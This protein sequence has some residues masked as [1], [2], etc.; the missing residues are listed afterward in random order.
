MRTKKL[1]PVIKSFISSDEKL[2]TILRAPSITRGPVIE[3]LVLL[4][5]FVNDSQTANGALLAAR[6]ASLQGID[7]NLR[8]LFLT[9]WTKALFIQSSVM[10]KRLPEAWTL[11]RQAENLITPASPPEIV[12]HFKLA[13]SYLVGSEGNIVR[14]EETIKDALSRIKPASHRYKSILVHFASFLAQLGRMNEITNDLTTLVNSTSDADRSCFSAL[15]FIDSVETGRLD[16]ARLFQKKASTL[17]AGSVV[18]PIFD[19]TM[20]LFPLMDPPHLTQTVSENSK[21]KPGNP[22]WALTLQCLSNGQIHQALRWA[23]LWERTHGK[24]IA[25]KGLISFNLIRAELAEGNA[26]AARRL[27][28][29]RRECGNLHYLDEFFLARAELLDGHTKEATAMFKSAMNAVDAHNADGRLDFELRL[30]VE[31]RRDMLMR[32]VRNSYD[33]PTEK[34]NKTISIPERR[35]ELQPTGLQ[36]ITGTSKSLDDVRKMI[37]QFTDLD[38]PVLITG[39]T[40]TGKE[41][42]ARA[43]HESGSRALEPFLAINC[44]AISESLLESELFG[45]EKGAFSGAATSHRGLFEEA[46]KGT[47]LLDEI[48]EISPRLQVALLRVLD[49]MEVRSVGSSRSR[50]IECRI[51]ASTNADL[52]KMVQNNTFRKDILFRL[53]R[54]E[55]NLTPL[56]ERTADILPLAVHFLDINR[57]EGVHA[58]MSASLQKTIMN[59]K[60]PGNVRELRNIIEKMRL[61]HSDK[62]YYDK[63]DLDIRMKPEGDLQTNDL[64]DAEPNIE[65]KTE[66]AMVV[67]IG[68]SRA[69]RLALLRHLFS[70]HDILTRSEIVQTFKISPNTATADLKQLCNEEF[71]LRIKPSKS[72][73][74]VYFKVKKKEENM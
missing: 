34:E 11:L 56:R 73:R 52:N 16:D 19:A 35:E 1:H 68:R 15:Q 62:L 37:L 47:I 38:V 65:E 53:Q 40:G 31:I 46:G 23:R 21:A 43:L 18:A 61:L 55:I 27:L 39:E 69:R 36:R 74:S 71:I 64:P 20:I 41:V 26:S 22:D 30:A 10:K 2:A 59:Y 4:C 45:H 48:G 72:P 17:D 12:S 8:I 60:W 14:Q 50:R 9:T 13:E 70:H 44:G 5:D 29:M 28:E 33:R 66:L 3:A 24:S 25:G 51:L 58:M 57:E 63:N 49:T 32:I 7:A 6:D 42:V 67:Q 54:L